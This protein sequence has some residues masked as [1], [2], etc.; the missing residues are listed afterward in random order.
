MTSTGERVLNRAG[1]LK[2]G[3]MIGLIAMW[4]C[5]VP[6]KGTVVA[7]V[8]DSYLT[9]EA[10]DRR[11]PTP[12][13]G[14]LSV[15]EKRRLVENWIEEE[16]LYREALRQKLDRDPEL[17][18]R[19]DRAVRQL[20]AGELMARQHERNADVLQDEILAYYEAHRADFEREKPELRVRHI[21]LKDAQAMNQAW[22]RLQKG[23]FFG[24]LAG[25][26]S[27]DRSASKGGDLGYFTEDMVSP[28]F[29]A[30]CRDVKPGHRVRVLTALGHHI[31]EVL[32][33]REAG[34]IRELTEVR[35]EI[36]LR[37]LTERR[38]EQRAKLLADLK[39]RLEWS[40]DLEKI[41]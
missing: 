34:S 39:D 10:L 21:V 32:D 2:L 36:Q 25:E 23:A 22:E 14:K 19:I 9:K 40:M 16:L 37:V 3:L 38:R 26:I 12:F 27:I 17:S 28:D 31:I 30:A 35:D 1:C 8:G 33:R 18:D 11:I 7:Q 15:A 29:W 13:A 41:E 20:L 4:G 24:Q 5:K 6:P